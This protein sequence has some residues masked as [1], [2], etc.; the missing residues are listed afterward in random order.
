MIRPLD[1]GLNRPQRLGR[2]AVLKVG[3]G[4]EQGEVERRDLATLDF[5]ASRLGTARIGVGE[6]VAEPPAGRAVSRPQGLPNRSTFSGLI[7]NS[8]RISP[9]AG[10]RSG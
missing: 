6:G 7:L 9:P 10:S 3:F 5:A 8:T 4:P 1:R 2:I